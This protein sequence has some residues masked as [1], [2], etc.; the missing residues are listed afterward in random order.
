VVDGWIHLG[1]GGFVRGEKW[2]EGGGVEWERRCRLEEDVAAAWHYR[3]AF[4]PHEELSGLAACIFTGL[5]QL[6]EPIG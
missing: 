3:S 6:C 4:R 2:D 5:S 1:E